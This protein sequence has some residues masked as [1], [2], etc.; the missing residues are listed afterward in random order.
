MSAYQNY[1]IAKIMKIDIYR[2]IVILNT[3]VIVSANTAGWFTVDLSDYNI[4]FP[5]N[6]IFIMMEWINGGDKYYYD[7]EMNRKD[8]DG[9]VVKEVRK[10]YGQTIGS[11]LNMPEMT[12][13]GITVGNDWTPWTLNHKGYINAMINADIAY[14]L[15]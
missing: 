4:P 14:P 2:L 13:W 11:V 10:F 6:G 7:K 15:E 5:I 8:A 3:N 12:T 9:K 1:S